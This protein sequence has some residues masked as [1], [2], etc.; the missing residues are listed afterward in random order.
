MSPQGP[1]AQPDLAKFMPMHHELCHFEA[2]LRSL[3]KMTAAR[4]GMIGVPSRGPR[5]EN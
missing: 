5:E 3:A 1:G 4:E 2:D